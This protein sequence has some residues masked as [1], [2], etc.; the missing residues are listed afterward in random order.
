MSGRQ[1][2]MASKPIKSILYLCYVLIISLLLLE[3]LIRLFLSDYAHYNIYLDNYTQRVFNTRT[4]IKR[5]NN[6]PYNKKFGFLYSPDTEE[7]FIT[8]EFKYTVKTNSLGFRSREISPKH[9]NEYRILIIGDSMC[10]GVGVD[11]KDTI[12]S[13][14][15]DIFLKNHKTGHS[16]QVYNFSVSG[17]DNVQELA[18]AKEFAPKIKPDIVIMGL[19]IANDILSNAVSFID[20]HGNYQISNKMTNIMKDN[21][22]NDL[23]IFKYSALLRALSI[24]IYAPRVRYQISRQPSVIEKTFSIISQA[25]KYCKDNGALFCLL[26]IYPRDSIQGGIIE[27]WSQSKRVGFLIN[28]FCH[29]HGILTINTA[30]IM[31]GKNDKD[32][33]YYKKDGHFNKSGNLKIA[34]AIYNAIIK[35]QIVNK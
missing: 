31:K 4:T 28:Q 21:I 1:G 23:G 20:S 2:L 13:Y 29:Q 19:F 9:D 34:Q 24:P 10:F 33:Y 17:Y 30:D 7:T 32:K 18:V 27:A 26:I 3:V 8:D 5:T 22:E 14:L 25:N 11:Q 35:N 6:N 16:L 15:E 12:E